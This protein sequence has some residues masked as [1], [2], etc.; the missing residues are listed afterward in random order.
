MKEN[1]VLARIV[2]ACNGKNVDDL[3]ITF[4]RSEIVFLAKYIELLEEKELIL[5]RLLGRESST[6]VN[7]FN[8]K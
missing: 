7:V 3:V 1:I 5:N 6:V 2:D 4:S 8:N